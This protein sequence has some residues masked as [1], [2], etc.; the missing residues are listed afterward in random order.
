MRVAEAVEVF[1]DAK[2]ADG[3]SDATVRWY[4]SRLRRF[5]RFVKN[6]ALE[7]VDRMRVRQFLVSLRSQRTLY[8]DH[9]YR[10]EVEGE[11]SPWTRQ[12]YVRAVKQF[13]K[14][15]VEEGCLPKSPAEHI[16]MG[17]LPK[18]APKAI[19]QKTLKA[20]LDACETN[21]EMGKRDKALLLFLADT[22]C[23][24]GGLVG[25]RVRDLDL[26]EGTAM[27]TEKGTKSRPVMFSPITGEAIG[28]WVETRS[29][30][31]AWVFPNSKTGDALHTTGVNQIIRRLAKRA[32]EIDGCSN[33]HAF[34]H[35]FAR[36]YILNGGDLATLSDLLGHS[37]VNVTKSFYSR[38]EFKELKRKH[39][40]F[41]PVA[42]LTDDK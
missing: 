3:V 4:G 34:R 31:S 22:G 17:R 14:W 16:R 33:P 37:N 8:Q 5:A 24:V 9:P 7:D 35:A 6:C 29:V 30:S 19:L 27:V 28:D 36:E 26:E 11:L 2:I 18:T 10:K 39:R 41:S 12:G 20:L 15:M 13:F 38:F 42:H 1:L 23:R 40:K 21:D 32:G 25:L